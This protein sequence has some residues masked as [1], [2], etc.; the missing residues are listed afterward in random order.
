[1]APN[2]GVIDLGTAGNI[3]SMVRA[4]T[5]VG[6]QVV[7]VQTAADCG[8][9][10]K[11]VLP[12]VGSFRAVMEQI[13]ERR[14]DEAIGQVARERPVLG[15]CLGMQLLAAIGYEHG[16]TQGLGLLRGEVRTLMCN[17]PVPHMGFAGVEVVRPAPILRGVDPEAEFYFMHSYEFINFTDVCGLSVYGGHQFVSAV[18]RDHV[19]GVQFHPEKSREHGL[20]LLRNFVEL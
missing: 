2:V 7:P 12:G 10:D 1:M 3:A 15:V 13:R 17:A 19:F 14:L 9:V 11:L 18:A 20:Q 4:L 5:A 8:R 16:E 6:A